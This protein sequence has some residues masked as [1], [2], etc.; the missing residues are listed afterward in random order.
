MPIVK[1]EPFVKSTPD[2]CNTAFPLKLRTPEGSLDGSQRQIT[3]RLRV[4]H[5]LRPTYTIL[6]KLENGEPELAAD[7][8]L[9]E[10][11]DEDGRPAPR[12]APIAPPVGNTDGSI[13]LSVKPGFMRLFDIPP[14]RPRARG[15]E[16]AAWS[17]GWLRCALPNCE[18]APS[19]VGVAEREALFAIYDEGVDKTNSR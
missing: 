11:E 17:M 15:N 3:R 9:G 2:A 19:G 10:S 13:S 1:E 4:M 7:G 6:E 18:V 16:C 5:N 12:P 14:R 8:R